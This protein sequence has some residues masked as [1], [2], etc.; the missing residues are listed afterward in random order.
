[1][2]LTQLTLQDFGL[3]RGHQV[4]QLS[5]KPSQP[6]ILFGGKNGAGKT[7]L[8][9]AIR[10]CLYG[11]GVLGDRISK[12]AYL[13][14]LKGR[15]HSNSNFLIQ[16][17]FASV[18]LEFQYADVGTVHTYEVTRSWEQ[19]ASQRIIEHLDIKRNG[20]PLN[21]VSTE[22]W[23]DFV[24]ELIPPGVS[25]L[26]F[27]DG[28]KIQQLADDASDQQT[29]ADAIKSLFGLDAVERLHTDL[30]IYVSRFTKPTQAGKEGSGIEQLQKEIEQIQKRLDQSRNE[31][32]QLENKISE[33]RL[34]IARV[35]A[36]ITSEGG[37]F[38]R[39]R[40]NLHDQQANLKAQ[41]KQHEG[42]LR[43]SS[44]GLLPFAFV[45]KL[46]QQLK[47]QLS[48]EEQATQAQAGRSLLAAAK[49]EILRRVGS[50]NFWASLPKLPPN[51]KKAVLS[52]L[53]QEIKAPLSIEQSQS[54]QIIHQ[55]SL[56]DHQR[57]QSWINQI[58]NDLSK[59][60]QSISRELE[61]SYRELQKVE[62]AL[63]KIPSDDVLKPLVEELNG[64]H[65]TL[66]EFGK[67]A[68]IMDQD[69]RASE[70][71]LGECQRRYNQATENLADQASNVSR[72]QLVP[73]IQNI[74]QEYKS[75][76]IEK[77]VKQLQEEVTRCFNVLCRK[78]DALR[79][80]AIDPKDFSVTFFDRQ[81]R[82]MPKAHLSAGEKQI[83]AISML[84]ALAAIS[85]RPLPMIIDTPLARLDSDHR[86]ILVKQYFPAASHQV[87]IL[88]TD[89][90][91][92]Q[93]YFSQL[94]KNIATTYRLDF[95]MEENCTSI[96]PGY[97]W[98]GGDE[99]H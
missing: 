24:R 21:E 90:E 72:V 81:N 4:I 91:V 65:Q 84:W 11:P 61:V 42:T 94:R 87:I 73:R 18:A 56:S 99:A 22:H 83:Y 16:P 35:E 40:T 93:S 29:L 69:I 92:D 71:Q 79:K 55:L 43:Q 97:F 62:E 68:F 13:H 95:V 7:T 32:Q 10:L 75:A 52:R 76:L 64:L 38:V 57:I 12:E 2:I 6:I 51:T 80:I 88:S 86:E 54:V 25:Q 28:E 46:C 44:A 60:A 1:M 58:T 74:L 9:E 31:R 27:F 96:Q 5:S 59:R 53:K 23:Q 8:L 66:G 15:I 85:G 20:N 45:P 70:S 63:K 89:T 14:Y 67:Q 36:K 37:L 39:N 82:S 33:Q 98:K 34:V 30:G 50:T 19:R 3:F 26:F 47:D 77:K 78:K 49:A 17:T 48:L 41:I